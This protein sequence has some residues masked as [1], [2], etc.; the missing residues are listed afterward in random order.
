MWLQVMAFKAD[1]L[2]L[3]K[4]LLANKEYNSQKVKLVFSLER[5]N[6]NNF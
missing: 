5:I 2:Y 6:G 1:M 3:F 4:F